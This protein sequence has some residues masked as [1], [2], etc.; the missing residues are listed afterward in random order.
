MLF[1]KPVDKEHSKYR[2]H[3]EAYK[4]YKE[5]YKNILS[6]QNTVTLIPFH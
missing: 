3:K 2:K 5:A 4:K 1:K 6:I